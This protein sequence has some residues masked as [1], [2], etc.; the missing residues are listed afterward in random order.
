MFMVL[1]LI[2]A[3]DHSFPGDA[4]V[5]QELEGVGLADCW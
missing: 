1:R 3:A 2:A 5:N 4:A